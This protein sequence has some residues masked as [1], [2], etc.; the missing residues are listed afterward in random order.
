MFYLLKR[1]TQNK[2]FQWKKYLIKTLSTKSR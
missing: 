1:E 2:I